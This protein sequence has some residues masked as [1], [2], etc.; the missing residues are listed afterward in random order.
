MD[1]TIF[2]I[3]LEILSGKCL[4]VAYMNVLAKLLL[5]LER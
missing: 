4:F 5:K 1:F 2:V 3:E